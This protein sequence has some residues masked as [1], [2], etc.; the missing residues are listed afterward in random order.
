VV[1]GS[2]IDTLAAARRK[3][4]DSG[5][6]EN[7]CAVGVGCRNQVSVGQDQ[8]RVKGRKSSASMKQSRVSRT[9]V[10][11]RIRLMSHGQRRKAEWTLGMQENV[12]YVMRRKP[13]D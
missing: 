12:S 7:V 13:R 2:E 6:Q 4:S 11:C 9:I 10:G 5:M 8:G 3:L 1:V